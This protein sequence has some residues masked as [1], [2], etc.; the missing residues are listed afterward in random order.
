MQAAAMKGVSNYTLL[1]FIFYLFIEL[2]YDI[3]NITWR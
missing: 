1:C 3:I 2:D